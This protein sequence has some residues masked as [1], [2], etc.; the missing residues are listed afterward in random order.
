MPIA[1]MNVTVGMTK[2][3]RSLKSPTLGVGP[4][5]A[6]SAKAIE[7]VFLE[8]LSVPITALLQEGVDALEVAAIVVR[9]RQVA[10]E[11]VSNPFLQ[12]P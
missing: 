8:L 5:C 7:F 1:A 12:F 2:R 4:G 11:P 9:Q 10:V 6:Q 3:A